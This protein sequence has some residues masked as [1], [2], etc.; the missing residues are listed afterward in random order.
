ML[1]KVLTR[2]NTHL[3]EHYLERSKNKDY[4]IVTNH[5]RRGEEEL[6]KRIHQKIDEIY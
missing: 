6:K 4:N 2:T 1:D 3:Y 5:I